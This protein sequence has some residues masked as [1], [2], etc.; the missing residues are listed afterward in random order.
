MTNSAMPAALFLCLLL[1][2]CSGQ[3]SNFPANSISA[4]EAAQHVGSWKTVCGQVASSNWASTSRGQPTFLNLDQPYPNQIF[5]VVIWGQN[6]FR[7]SSPP[8]ELYRNRF[9]C[10]TGAIAEYRGVP[11]VVINMPRQITVMD[12]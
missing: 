1:V 3:E 2:A 7:F 10:A 12:E 11:Q 4:N 5:T 6:R 9:V 8:E